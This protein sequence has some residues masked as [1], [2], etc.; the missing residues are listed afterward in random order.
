MFSASPLAN[1]ESSTSSAF[2]KTFFPGETV[3]PESDPVRLISTRIRNHRI[4]TMCLEYRMIIAGYLA[5]L[6]TPEDAGGV[7]TT[8]KKLH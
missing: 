2:E 6:F 7:F 5:A 4:I 3:F 1:R 8:M